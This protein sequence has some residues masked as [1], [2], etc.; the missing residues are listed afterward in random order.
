LQNISA[1]LG[2]ELSGHVLSTFV[3]GNLVFA[4]GKHAGAA[5]GVTV[6]AK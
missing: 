5:C 2:K 6:L 3:R 4:D 1:Y